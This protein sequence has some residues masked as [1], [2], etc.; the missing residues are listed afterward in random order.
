MTRSK[1]FQIA[2]LVLWLILVSPPKVSSISFSNLFQW[3]R[4]FNFNGWHL[5]LP[6]LSVNIDHEIVSWSGTAALIRDWGY[7]ERFQL[8]KR[9]SLVTLRQSN[10]TEML[11]VR[12]EVT[13]EF[14]GTKSAIVYDR[15]IDH[16]VRAL[17]AE[18]TGKQVRGVLFLVPTKIFANR[19]TVETTDLL[20][21]DRIL[22]DIPIN[23]HRLQEFYHQQYVHDK[24][25]RGGVR[26]IDVKSIYERL[27]VKHGGILYPPGESHWS[28]QI[29]KDIADGVLADL[30]SFSLFPSS[31]VVEAK[32][33]RDY[34]FKGNT[35]VPEE[36]ADLL[37]LGP[38]SPIRKRLSSHQP[39]FSF[40]SHQPMPECPPIYYVG[41]SYGA[42]FDGQGGVVD[43][44]R[45][46]Y[47]GAV[48]NNSTPGRLRRFKGNMSNQGHPFS[49]L[50]ILIWEFP[51]RSLKRVQGE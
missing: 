41:S 26:Y 12:E 45:V 37:R 50:P 13:D 15:A 20:V 1:Y 35:L 47:Q 30:L 33:G 34:F 42:Y 10:I 3:H 8:F 17:M 21:H 48:H 7:E 36:L 24:L 22:M 5:Y 43:F 31:C 49:H 19:P 46:S 2:T 9:S 51:F 23:A 18:E 4:F 14:M 29:T 38:R 16:V 40:T 25:S 28:T 6:G 39:T 27:V 44:M 11:I 32:L